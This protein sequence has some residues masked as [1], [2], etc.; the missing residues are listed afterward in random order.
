MAGA[1]ISNSEK[2]MLALFAG[3]IYGTVYTKQSK[4]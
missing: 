4:C 3:Y 1:V 2:C